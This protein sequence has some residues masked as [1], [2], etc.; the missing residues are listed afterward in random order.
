M[1]S[2]QEALLFSSSDYFLWLYDQLGEAR[3]AGYLKRSGWFGKEI[4]KDWLGND[5]LAMV[6]GW[7]LKISPNQQH[8]FIQRVMNGDLASN[9]KVQQ[10]LKTALEWPSQNSKVRLFGK[11]GTYGGVVWFNGFGESDAGQKAVTVVIFE[12][13][14]RRE[15]AIALF[16]ERW[17]EPVPV[18]FQ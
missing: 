16:Y 3:F 18:I 7:N 13:G 11:T 6:R 17:K 4:P 5:A 14:G 1:I 8:A 2:L 9:E 15:K 10:K 12:S